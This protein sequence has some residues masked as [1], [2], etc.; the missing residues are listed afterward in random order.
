MKKEV[1]LNFFKDVFANF[2]SQQLLKQLLLQ[3]HTNQDFKLDHLLNIF[4]EVK[5]EYSIPLSIFS[6]HLHPAEALCKYLKEKEGLNN[7]EIAVLLNRHQKSVWSTYQRARQKM[8]K[9]F[10]IKNEQY[11][12]PLSIFN[13][14][15]YSLLES[16]VQY[17]NHT[18]K[19]SNKQVAK[20]LGKSSNSIAV[21]AKRAREKDD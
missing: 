10:S 4:N 18:H 1:D 9:K 17:M 5:Q 2:S 15:S 12:L 13:N 7:Q 14:R 3:L 16:V 20:L 6:H 21:L 19:L 11:H 8:R